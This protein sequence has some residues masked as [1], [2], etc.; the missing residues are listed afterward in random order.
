[1]AEDEVPAGT[2]GQRGNGAARKQLPLVISM[3]SDVVVAIFIPAE[4]QGRPWIRLLSNAAGQLETPQAPCVRL[5]AF[6]AV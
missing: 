6:P 2:E 3:L 5:M 1:M 4:A